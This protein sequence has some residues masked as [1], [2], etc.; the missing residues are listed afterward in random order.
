MGGGGVPGAGGVYPGA[1][2]LYWSNMNYIHIGYKVGPV[3]SMTL[4]LRIYFLHHLTHTGCSQSVY[5]F[6]T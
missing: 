2:E 5:L 1:G 6:C 4:Y 3:L